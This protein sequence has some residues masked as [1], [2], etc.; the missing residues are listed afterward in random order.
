MLPSRIPY[1]A[2]LPLCWADVRPPVRDAVTR[3]V[4]AGDVR[5][6]RQALSESGMYAELAALYKYNGRHEEGLELLRKLSQEPE[7]LPRAARGA[8][9]G[10][11]GGRGRRANAA[12]EVQSSNVR[13]TLCKT[14]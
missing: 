10:G 13:N 6:S 3:S 4:D 9:A 5:P 2:R 11:R 12:G 14:P 7:A 1:R 8:A